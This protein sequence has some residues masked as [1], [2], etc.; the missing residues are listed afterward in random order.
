MS[1]QDE[2]L[3][4]VNERWKQTAANLVRFAGGHIEVPH[5]QMR[6]D[7]PTLHVWE[8]ERPEGR[9]TVWSTTAQSEQPE[10]QPVPEPRCEYRAICKHGPDAPWPDFTVG[11]DTL[12]EARAAAERLREYSSVRGETAMPHDIK[13]QVRYPG[14]TFWVDYTLPEPEP[15]PGFMAKIERT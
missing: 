2:P 14:S 5:E 10:P 11:A 3:A 9:V 8:E 15:G 1:Q 12:D 6:T 4:H 7:I 13:V